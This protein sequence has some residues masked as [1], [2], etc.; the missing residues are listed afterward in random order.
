MKRHTSNGVRGA[1][2]SIWCKC[3][4]YSRTTDRSLPQPCVH[5]AALVPPPLRR[6]VAASSFCARTLLLTAKRK[7]RALLSRVGAT[8]ARARYARASLRCTTEDGISRLA[9]LDF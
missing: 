2:A 4:A 8:S 7:Y 1:L 3:C 5:L 9:I 6:A